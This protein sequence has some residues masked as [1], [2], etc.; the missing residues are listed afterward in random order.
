MRSHEAWEQIN[1]NNQITFNTVLNILRELDI[2]DGNKRLENDKL[3]RSQLLAILG[4]IATGLCIQNQFTLA[5]NEPTILLA[6]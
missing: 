4:C 5:K 2:K 3:F 1:T 6:E